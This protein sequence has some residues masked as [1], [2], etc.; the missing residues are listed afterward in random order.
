MFITI[1][2]KSGG[3]R[4]DIR[5]DNEQQISAGFM[6]LME[7]GKMPHGEVPAYFRSKHGEKLVSAYKTFHAEEVYDGDV[8]TAV[9]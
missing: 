5:I 3:H 9:V 4:A 7:S 8:L 6:T 1:T 2:V